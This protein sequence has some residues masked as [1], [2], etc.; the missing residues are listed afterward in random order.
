MKCRS[1]NSPCSIEGVNGDNDIAYNNSDNFNTLYDYV[2]F[3]NS[4]WVVLQYI[5]Y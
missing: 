1:S 5:Y 2:P 3:D 4:K